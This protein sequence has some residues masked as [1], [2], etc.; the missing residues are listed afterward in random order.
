MANYTNC[1]DRERLEILFKKNAPEP[2]NQPRIVSFIN[3]FWE[4]VVTAIAKGQEPQ[5]WRSTD[6]NGNTW[7]YAHDPTT[8]RSV[9]RDSEAEMRIWLEERYYH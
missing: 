3:K 5:V 4:Q 1:T 6:R 9:C 2:A 7:W 8:G